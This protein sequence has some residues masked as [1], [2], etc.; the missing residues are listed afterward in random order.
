MHL[1]IKDYACFYLGNCFCPQNKQKL[2]LLCSYNNIDVLEQTPYSPDL[3]SCDF[4]LLCKLKKVIKETRFQDSEA[5][6]TT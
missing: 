2:Q 4:F 5:I 1:E 3:A 6:E